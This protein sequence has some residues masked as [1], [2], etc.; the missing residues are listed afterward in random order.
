MQFLLR[1]ILLTIPVLLGVTLLTFAIVK[2]TPGD[3]VILMLGNSATPERVAEVRAQLGLDDP[4]ITQY[5]RYLSRLM[6]GDLGT[7]IRSKRPV[8]DE[9]LERLPSTLEL[10]V[11]ALVVAALL[12]IPFG[13]WAA[14]SRR[15]WLGSA[16][17]STTVVGMSIPN[18]WL[19]VI[20]L[21]VFGVNLR[22]VSV[23][24][25]DTL[26]GLVLAALCLGIGEAAIL[27]RLTYS[28]VREVLLAD[29]I[30]TA[31]AKGLARQTVLWRHA[32]RNALIPITT[33][34]GL[35][36]GGLMGGSLFIEAV[37]AR[38][39]LGRYAI[40]AIAA[41]DLPQ[42]Q[43]MVLFAAVIYVI[44]NLLVDLAY[45]WADP[46]LRYA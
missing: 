43:G 21:I 26:S 5:S 23:T 9:I 45:T 27:S 1:R 40:N 24:G 37:F 41:R 46:R 20:A 34:L 31:N 17:M 11:G 6:A 35:L 29:Y 38:S 44:V 2:L 15:R 30:R 12:G 36:F 19:A 16:L 8:L 32:L 13:I 22:W 42:I 14:A 3:P 39:G 25:G 18:F 10:A 33:Q 28:S 7:S 4:L